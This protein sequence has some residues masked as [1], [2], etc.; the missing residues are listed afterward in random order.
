MLTT[1]IEIIAKVADQTSQGTGT[2]VQN[3]S[4]IEQAGLSM[5]KTLTNMSKMTKLEITASL[6]D[7]AT[8]GLTGIINLGKNIM[9]KTWSVTSKLIDYA[10]APIKSILNL[11]KNPIVQ[12]V[13]LVGITAGVADTISTYASYEQSLADTKAVT[14]ASDAEMASI[15]TVVK[16]L[17]ASTTFT[18]DDVGAGASVLGTA[19]WGAEQITE[20]LGGIVTMAQ[21]GSVDIATAADINTST[22]AQYGLQASDSGYV[23]DVLAS[24]AANSK[25]DISGLGETFKYVGSTASALEYSLED[26]AIAVGLL[27]NAAI[28]GSQAGTSLRTL[29]TNLVDPTSD[30]QAAMEKLGISLSDQN[31]EMNSL[32]DIMLQ[33]RVG[34]STLSAEEQ[35]FYASSLA[36]TEGLSGLLAIANAGQEDFDK[37][38]ESIYGSAGAAQQMA[39]TRV[40]SLSGDFAALSSAVDGVKISIGERLA[41]TLRSFTQ[42][43]TDYVPEIGEAIESALTVSQL[44]FE[45]LVETPEWEEA[46]LSQKI[47]LTWGAMV[48]EPF[49]EW[50]ES[51]GKESA[52]ALAGNIGTTL[53]GVLS[54]GL[55]TLL[56]IDIGE[57]VSDGM[58]IGKAFVDGFMEGFDFDGVAQGLLNAFMSVVGEASKILPFGEEATGSSWLAAGFLGYAGAKV[59]GAGKTL[60]DVGS[61]VVGAGTSLLGLGKTGLTT[62]VSGI[63][64]GLSKT[65]SFLGSGLSNL[66]AG[67]ALGWD[68]LTGAS[69]AEEWTGSNSVSNTLV[70]GVSAMIGGTGDGWSSGSLLEN[71]WDTVTNTAKGAATGAAVGAAGWNPFTIA[72]GAITGGAI[73]FGTSI[74]GGETIASSITGYD[75]NEQN[76]QVEIVVEPNIFDSTVYGSGEA[77]QN[78][79]LYIENIEENLMAL[80]DKVEDVNLGFEDSLQEATETAGTAISDS[81]AEMLG[82]TL[83]EYMDSMWEGTGENLE[84]LAQIASEE[85]GEG[86]SAFFGEEIPLVLDG[87]WDDTENKMILATETAKPIVQQGIS[88]FFTSSIPNNV[89]SVWDSGLSSL[90][91]A[92]KTASATISSSAS[93]F[94][95]SATASISSFFESATST[96]GA[97][98]SYTL[99]MESEVPA[100]AEGGFLD[101]ARLALVGED[102]PEVIIPLGEKRRSRGIALWEEAGR[103]LGVPAYAEGGFVGQTFPTFA[104]GGQGNSAVTIQV[105]V[106]G[107]SMPITVPE[108]VTSEKALLELIL[109][110]MEDLAEEV[111]RELAKSLEKVFSNMPVLA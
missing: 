36:G 35:A 106:G 63:G 84:E 13:T 5:Q 23:G 27:G 8:Q 57:S 60:W 50:W 110:N 56:G 37:L 52:L 95:A 18:A 16:D 108:G 71:I 101:S 59:A 73:G 11:V 69:K 6:K 96:M 47:S 62:A 82:E 41:P 104:S 24:T 12:T 85:I 28:D 34:F 80:D 64:S 49:S 40:D 2:A 29:F 109:E 66:G 19:G 97:N 105:D 21:A 86:I 94:F 10:T 58:L 1:V 89:Q 65:G 102:G 44:R 103:Q 48:G 4:K 55:M 100:Y 9:G 74:V 107:V 46:D 26:T 78:N 45:A 83:P 111:A 67:I 20:G 30:T 68:A 39:D 15:S 92:S 38:T 99:G 25:T 91:S 14:G 90:K 32:M 77:N 54:G 76:E 88:D 42:L 98:A 31:G 3:L 75:K 81:L 72:A 93:A 51:G 7:S 87:I 79:R 22:I 61:G 33:L 43:A 70:S 53:G 17:G